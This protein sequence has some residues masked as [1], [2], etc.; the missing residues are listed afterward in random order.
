M[1]KDYIAATISESVDAGR[2]ADL[3]LDARVVLGGGAL[4]YRP[5][6]KRPR[7]EA[8]EEH[9]HREPAHQ[10]G[11]V[12]KAVAQAGAG[13]EIATRRRGRKGRLRSRR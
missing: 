5:R 9:E 1:N 8:V 11:R 13:Q 4:G 2:V 10:E 12:E 3:H 7:D 6:R